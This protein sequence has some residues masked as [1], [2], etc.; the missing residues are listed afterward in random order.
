MV[1][2]VVTASGCGEGGGTSVDCRGGTYIVYDGFR[3]GREKKKKKE[4]ERKRCRSTTTPE[5]ASAAALTDNVSESDRRRTDIIYTLAV[6]F[7]DHYIFTIVK[8]RKLF[9]L[10]SNFDLTMEIA[11]IGPD[12]KRLFSDRL[13]KN[14]NAR[15]PCRTL[16]TDNF[17]LRLNPWYKGQNSYS[18]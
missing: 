13:R 11:Q 1:V 9:K 18:F 4:K 14:N 12:V 6:R 7:C 15:P 8:S 16:K 17:G 2:A 5:R 10:W 3:T